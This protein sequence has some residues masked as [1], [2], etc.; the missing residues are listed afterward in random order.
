MLRYEVIGLAGLPEIDERADLATLI[1]HAWQEQAGDARAGDVLVV[2]QK[3]V[4]K[5]EGCRVSLAELQPSPFART[6]AE[7][8]G[9][10]ARLIELVLRES[11]RVVRMDRGVLIVETHHG[12]VCANAGVDTS[13]VPPGWALTLPRDPDASACRLREH[14]EARLGVAPGVIV[15]DTFGRPW[16]E[17]LTNVAIG[18]AGV[19]PLDDHR[20]RPD[21]FGRSLQVS[22]IAIADEIASAA[23]LVMGK[24]RRV[25]AVVIRG[26]DV[27]AEDSD[28]GAL[29][30][31]P[32]H[33]L[34]R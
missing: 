10:D 13:N 25:P 3:V 17:G 14:L 7:A 22:V 11:R 32:A 2:A 21:T 24:T 6:W 34:F 8:H 29:R 5:A 18:I 19:Q 9:R 20:G 33:D 30:R 31:D 16:R 26:L 23:E 28:A 12:L 27:A 4:S 1:A 15:A